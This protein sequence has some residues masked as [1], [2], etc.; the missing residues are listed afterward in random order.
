MERCLNLE[1]GKKITFHFALHVSTV[2]KCDEMF[3][4]L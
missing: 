1:T 2:E 4:G 3:P